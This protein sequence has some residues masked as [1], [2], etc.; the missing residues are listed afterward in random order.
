VIGGRAL[1]M[2]LAAASVAPATARATAQ[3]SNEARRAA[4]AIEKM[5][6]RHGKDV[7]RCFEKALA[8]RL[9]VSGKVEMEV[10]AGEGGKVARTR[11]LSSGREVS[12]QL[13]SCISLAAAAWRVEGIEP[14]AAL[15]LPF[16]FE[17]Q[18]SQ[19]VVKVADVPDRSTAPRAKAAGPTRQAPFT[20]KVLADEANLRARHV[21][22][23]LLSIGPASRVTMH[24]HPR[25]AKI[26]YLLEGRARLLSPGGTEKMERGQVAFVPAGY[27]HVI[28]NMNRQ[29]TAVFL[30]AFAPPGP[31]RVYRD[32]TDV[33]GRA[34]FEVIRDPRGVKIP[35]GAKIVVKGPSDA[36]ALPMLGGKGTARILLDEGVTGTGAL[37]VDLVEF[38]PGVEVP[39]HTHPGSTE[40][41]Y[42]LGGAGTLL[43]GSESHPF[44]AASV[45][46][47]PPDQPHG[48]KAGPEKVTAVQIYA[49]AGP[50]QRFRK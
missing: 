44:T 28:E 6:Q 48:M 32:P 18:M 21:S 35:D 43:V 38:S 13:S 45:L 46:H 17:G 36:P 20:V 37:S 10:E 1:V 3:P 2:A 33:Q 16:A 40:L 7:H 19:F 34:D 31:E 47:V 24:R 4:Q 14:G 9:D 30:Q 25:S 22:L 15:V 39:R 50:E 42:V 8:D 27:P 29:S 11:V 49:P 12:P 5:L 41:L 26:L 23:T